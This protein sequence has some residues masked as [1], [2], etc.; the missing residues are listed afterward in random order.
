[1][2]KI[3]EELE[4]SLDGLVSQ[5]TKVN[6]L[7]SK[8]YSSASLIDK[9]FTD[10]ANAID[11]ASDRLSKFREDM[12]KLDAQSKDIGGYNTLFTQYADIVD[13]ITNA[14]R[15]MRGTNN[16]GLKGEYQSYINA[17]QQ[18]KDFLGGQLG[19]VS[20]PILDNAKK[21]IQ[22]PMGSLTDAI[23]MIAPPMDMIISGIGLGVVAINKGIDALNDLASAIKDSTLQQEAQ[24]SAIAGSDSVALAEGMIGSTSF[25]ENLDALTMAQM[26]SGDK[27]RFIEAIQDIKNITGADSST[28]ASAILSGNGIGDL[29]G[30][31][32]FKTLGL[33]AGGSVYAKE[34]NLNALLDITDSFISQ[35]G[36]T[37]EELDQLSNTITTDSM[38]AMNY[39][40]NALDKIGKAFLSATEPMFEFI[41]MLADAGAFNGWIESLS[42]IWGIVGEAVAFLGN[43]IFL[44]IAILS[45]LGKLL[46]LLLTPIK[47]LFEF[48]NSSFSFLLG[49]DKTSNR[50]ERNIESVGSIVNPIVID[51]DSL[52]KL[53][54]LSERQYMT[55]VNMKQI[56]PSVSMTVN[57]GADFNYEEAYQYM[58]RQATQEQASS[59]NGY[60]R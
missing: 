58:I 34:G 53:A 23:S 38:K 10:N 14:Q 40:N 16:E 59:V 45:P 31:P 29:L 55:N 4:L 18:Q 25:K 32:A 36:L 8:L 28:I 48:I 21:M 1:M 9:G 39:L 52:N 22:D 35:L 60:Y 49:G 47:A 37:N 30:L 13:E 11:E 51:D 46:N 56:T 44:I 6:Q 2:A 19:I 33:S 27:A 20:S 7:N 24:L 17:L 43:T 26:F 5:L 42:A 50:S 54:E 41:N 3:D 15:I 12:K 57:N